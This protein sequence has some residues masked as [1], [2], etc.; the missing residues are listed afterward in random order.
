MF[1]FLYLKIIQPQDTIYQTKD[2][3]LYKCRKNTS[4]FGILNE[5][6]IMHEYSQYIQNLNSS[7]CIVDFGA[8]GGSFSIFM[9]HRLKCSVFSFEP[10]P[11]NYQLLLENINL[12]SLS[13]L[14]KPFNYAISD[15][16]KKG[17]LY[18]SNN[19]NQGIHSRFKVTTNPIE[20]DCI[21]LQKVLEFVNLPIDLLKIDIEGA[22]HEILDVE[23]ESF[24]KN[25]YRIVLEYHT[26]SHFTNTQSLEHITNTILKLGFNIDKIKGNPE[27]GIIAAQ[28][29]I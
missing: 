22:E 14:I 2:H 18:R 20:I 13:T 11:N 12:N 1:I 6:L 16:N 26:Q 19:Q 8:Q 28:K 9:A 17:I 4:D 10:E 29:K 24:Y 15:Q 23:F 21:S 27:I 3:L 25:V 7:S 5:V